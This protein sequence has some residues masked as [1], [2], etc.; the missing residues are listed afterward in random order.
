VVGRDAI[1]EALE[2]NDRAAPNVATALAA[3][4]VP[5]ASIPNVITQA[6]AA[7]PMPTAGREVVSGWVVQIAAT[8]AEATAYDILSEAKQR[9]GSALADAQ[10]FTQAVANG[11]QT[12]YRARFSG[13]ADKAAANAACDALKSKAYA[14]Y[15][16]AAN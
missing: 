8:P 11:S 7:T 13:F 4:P 9:A 6:S 5:R 15:A 12:L 3:A 10:A 16:I 2:A 14:C 1:R